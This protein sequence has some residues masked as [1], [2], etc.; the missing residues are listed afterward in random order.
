MSLNISDKTMS[1][2]VQYYLSPL[3][4]FT[5]TVTRD[6]TISLLKKRKFETWR[7]DYSGFGMKNIL[8]EWT[9]QFT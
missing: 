1:L 3:D 7:F 4:L 9:K 6:A 5:K 8:F 2:I